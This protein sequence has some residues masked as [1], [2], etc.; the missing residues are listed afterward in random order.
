M[1]AR[2]RSKGGGEDRWRGHDQTRSTTETLTVVLGTLGHN[3][4]IASLDFPL[5]ARDDCLGNARGEDEVLVNR[6]DL[7]SASKR[8]PN[9]PRQI[10]YLLAD[11]PADGDSHHYQL[12]ALARP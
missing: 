5:L 9:H 7:G 10:T 6:V 1:G 11:I 4:K 3:N 2:G 8:P 12:R